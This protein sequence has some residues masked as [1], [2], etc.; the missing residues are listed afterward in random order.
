MKKHLIFSFAL[1]CL[2]FLYGCFIYDPS[3]E[4]IQQ[5]Y[6]NTISYFNTFYNAQRLFSEAEDAV[7]A[8][9][10]EYRETP[11]QTRAFTIPAAARSKFTASIEKNSKLLSFY[12]N[13]KWVGDALLMIGKAYYYTDDDVRAERK[14]L[15]LSAKYPGSALVVEARLWLG[16]SLFRQK[17]YDQ[18]L[19]LMEGLIEESKNGNTEIAGMASYEIGK[20]YFKN[21]EYDKAE[22]YFSQSLRYIDDGELLALIQ[23]QIAQCYENR[24]LFAKAEIAFGKVG[25]ESPG[26][27]LLFNAGLSRAKSIARQQR[28]DESL[29]LLYDMLD[30]TKNT[31]YFG[32]INFEIANTLMARGD[33]DDAIKK[34]IYVDTAF[35][36]TDVAARS[37]YALGK[38]F[39]SVDIN[40]DS[41]RN[42]YTKARTEF[43]ASAVTSD[44]ALKSEIYLKYFAL[45]KDVSRFDS[46]L[47]NARVQKTIDDSLALVAADSVRN[48]D[49]TSVAVQQ[50]KATPPGKK[51]DVK[52]DSIP[53][54]DST[55]IKA[56][57]AKDLAYRQLVDSLQ[58]SIVRTKFELGG[59]FF[60][61]MQLA[62]SA[63]YWFTYVADN[64]PQSEFSPRALYTIAEIYRSL[65]P[66]PKVVR[67]SLYRRIIAAYPQSQYAQEA[68]KILNLPIL[69]NE[70]DPAEELYQKAELLADEK[71][72]ASALAMLRELLLQYPASSLSPKAMYSLGWHYENSLGNNDSA[73][74]VYR[75]LLAGY[76]TTVY[77]GSIRAKVTEFDNEI[78]RLEQEKQQRIDEQ[79]KKEEAEKQSKDITKP[80]PGA[81]ADSLSTPQNQL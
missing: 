4:F 67:D 62:D 52:T 48:S 80:N 59:L 22:K 57:K 9:E 46:L 39:E 17:K 33:I 8:A 1:M 55:M 11:N 25:D 75:R 13:S 68:R 40:Y 51:S 60:V 72:Y 28:Y 32:S 6:T 3:A 49:T 63:L 36:R 23:F 79:K 27:T 20:H 69:E 18:A 47:I 12:P 42:Y 37:Y 24:G 26:Y 31:D 74:A 54:I 81:P 5:R 30:D 35:A 21:A 38:Y 41:A 34:Y 73:L 2:P 66:Q 50:R 53:P 7:L 16:R 10:K 14:F 76:P 56:R 78:K 19:S 58:R 61:E 43:P 70:N 45:W 65:K 29:E 71:K 77:A 44:A 15:E 64:Y